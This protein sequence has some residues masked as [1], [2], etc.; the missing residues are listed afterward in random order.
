[1]DILEVVTSVLCDSV[2]YNSITSSCSKVLAAA[3]AGGT[4]TQVYIP[5]NIL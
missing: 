2:H 5:P 3:S 1:M 4:N